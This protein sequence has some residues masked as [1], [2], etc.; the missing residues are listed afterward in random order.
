MEIRAEDLPRSERLPFVMRRLFE[1]RGYRR[2][3]MSNFETYDLYR[4]NKKFLES[5]AIITFTDTTGRLMALKPDV[6]MSIVKHTSPDTST[7]RLYYE[8]NVFRVAPQSG[9]YREISQMGLEYIGGQTGYGEAEVIELAVRSL[10]AIQPEALLSVGHMGFLAGMFEALRFSEAACAAALD[11]LRQKNGHALYQVAVQSGCDEEAAA[12]AA[13]LAALA[14]PF[15]QTLRAAKPLAANC[16]MR[17]ALRDL[18]TICAVLDAAGVADTLR[19]DFSA[20]NDMDYYNGVVFQGYVK[21][22][23]RAVL[24]GGRYDNL[25]RRFSKPQSAVGFAV[26]LG[27]LERAFASHAAYDVDTLLLYD[28]RQEPAAV[29]NAVQLLLKNADSVRA[30]QSAPEDVRARRVVRLAEDGT[31]R[32]AGGESSC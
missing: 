14:G 7:S 31:I 26:Y 15:A 32:P 19:L 4:E 13:S 28:P 11:A 21:G 1:K 17:C 22:A 16:A 27:E 2:Y 25:L 29:A 12:R 20:L 10:R 3:R 18:Q 5:E 6:T 9:E 24:A 23:P 8:E 30:E